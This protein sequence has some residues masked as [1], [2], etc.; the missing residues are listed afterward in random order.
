VKGGSSS[1][2][3]EGSEPARPG[4][5]GEQTIRSTVGHPYFVVGRGWTEARHLEVGDLLL[6][7]SGEMLEVRGL[8]VRSEH[9]RHYNFEVEDWHTYFVSE[10]A[11]APSVF[12]HNANGRN[13]DPEA[14]VAGLR[15][16]STPTGK[17]SGRF[18]VIHA[19]PTNYRVPIPHSSQTSKRALDIDGFDGTTVLEVK[20]L[21]NRARSPRLEGSAAPKFLK[22]IMRDQDA[23]EFFRIRLLLN[24][25]GNPFT[26]AR[27]ITNDKALVPYLR[28]LL[29][30][31][32]I[33]GE[34]VV[35]GWSR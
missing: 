9:A 32:E 29:D 30:G 24:D 14:F 26:N 3:E 11:E 6:A 34:V 25:P 8:R 18:E 1:D 31:F 20:F 10:K 13:C 33:P 35:K 12:V 16:S 2:G 19:G 21:G 23:D 7:A 5:D 15:Q 17:A 28:N 27:V 22:Q 4:A